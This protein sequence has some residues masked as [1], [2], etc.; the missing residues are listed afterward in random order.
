L[1]FVQL[2]G[3]ARI[4]EQGD[5]HA[6]AIALVR[7]RYAQYETMALESRPVIAIDVERVV[8]WSGGEES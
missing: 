2:R 5:E 6:R 3:A 8:E 1:R 4:I 7:A